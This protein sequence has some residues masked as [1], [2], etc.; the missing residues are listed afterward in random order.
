MGFSLGDVFESVTK[1]VSKAI[2]GVSKGI[3][4]ILGD[5]LCSALTMGALNLSERILPI[6]VLPLPVGPHTTYNMRI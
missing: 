4:G 3:S 5:D 1:P 2:G 6:S